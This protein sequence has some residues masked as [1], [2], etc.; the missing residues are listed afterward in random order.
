MRGEKCWDPCL[1]GAIRDSLIPIPVFFKVTVFPSPPSGYGFE[2]GVG[3]SSVR[4]RDDSGAPWV[5][6]PRCEEGWLERLCFHSAIVQVATAREA[7]SQAIITELEEQNQGSGGRA[8]GA[9]DVVKVRFRYVGTNS[10]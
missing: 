5:L 3:G 1:S 6:V 8:A 10:I 2:I 9:G 4:L 7:F